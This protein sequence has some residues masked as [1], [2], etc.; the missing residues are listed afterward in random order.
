MF[1]AIGRLLGLVRSHWL[2]TAA[3]LGAVVFAF[4]WV[5]GSRIPVATVSVTRGTAAEIVYA[6]GAIEPVRWAKVTTIVKGRIVERCRCEGKAVKAGDILARIDDAEAQAALREM[7]AREDFARREVERQSQLVT[8][9]FTSAQAFERSDSELRQIQ[10]LIAAQVERLANY[11]LLAPMDGVVL[12]EDGEVG[13]IVDSN[14]VL[15]R[16]GNPTPLQL[17]AEVNEADIP[18]VQVGQTV[19]LRSDAFPEGKLT[20]VV[21]EITP[22]GDPVTKTYRIRVSLPDQTPLRVGMSVE[23]NV[24]TKQ[25]DFVLLVPAAAISAGS[26]F[27]VEGNR[28]V[29]RAVSI[30]IRGTQAVEVLAGLQEEDKVISPLPS[31]IRDGAWVRVVSQSATPKK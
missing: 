29:R 24:V 13:E 20:G 9:G 5:G 21:R 4:W 22:A 15:Y 31:D 2:W 12:R 6:T 8:R 14:T 27:V 10:A 16:I 19:L 11:H 25:K 26:V 18:R 1:A 3:V 17:V 30:G 23:A 28:A 7:K